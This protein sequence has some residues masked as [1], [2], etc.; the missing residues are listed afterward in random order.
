MDIELHPDF[1]TN[2]RIYISFAKPHPS[3]AKYHM[4]P[5]ATGILQGN[6]I[7][8]LKTLINGDHY[9]WAPSNFGGALTFDNEKNLYISIGDRGN[10]P[11]SI[12]G[13]RLEN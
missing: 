3:A 13:D 1:S 2:K 12:K 9:D 10:E 11:F 7:V 5:V 8:D 4:T 6:Q